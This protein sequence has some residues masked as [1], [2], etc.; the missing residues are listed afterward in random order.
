ML[1]IIEGGPGLRGNP[2]QGHN[3]H[4]NRPAHAPHVLVIMEGEGPAH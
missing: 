1:M 4:G 3:R 2:D